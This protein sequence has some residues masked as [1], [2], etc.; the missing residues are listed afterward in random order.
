MKLLRTCSGCCDD[1]CS[2]FP[3][4]AELRSVGMQ[5]LDSSR[6]L[7]KSLVAS[8]L[9]A[10]DLCVP[11]LD[12]RYNVDADEVL[13]DEGLEVVAASKPAEGSGKDVIHSSNEES[14]H[15]ELGPDVTV[16]VNGAQPPWPLFE[17]CCSH[18]VLM[19]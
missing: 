12:G 16:L 4:A 6:A 10:A 3:F 14:A 9:R 15:N 17:C 1:W 7:V 11:Y 18:A 2:T 13:P 8:L 19:P 5:V